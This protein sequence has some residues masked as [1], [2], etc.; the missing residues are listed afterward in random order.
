MVSHDDGTVSPFTMA[1]LGDS[2]HALATADDPV[3]GL[4]RKLLIPH[5]AAKRLRAIES[6]VADTADRLWVE[7][8][9]RTHVEWMSS[10]ANRLPMMVVA[11]LIGVPDDVN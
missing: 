11:R 1:P 7:N 4:H 5:L 6:F 10:I 3:H 2:S 8:A 9:R